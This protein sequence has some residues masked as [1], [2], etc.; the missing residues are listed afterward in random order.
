M[1]DWRAKTR[2]FYGWWLVGALFCILFITGGGGFYVFPVFIQ[3]LIGEFGWTVTQISSA[4]ALWAIVYGFSGPVV[5]ALIARAG[6]RRT[7]VV[8]AVLSSIA[9]LGFARM[10][11]LWLL[12]AA[13]VVLGFS[14]AGTTLVPAQTVITNWFTRYRGRAMSWMMLGIGAGGLLMPPLMEW[15]IRQIGWR[16]TWLVASALTLLVVVPL[17]ALFV[18]TKPADLGLLPDG[19]V[20]RGGGSA[21]RSG[22]PVKLA[23]SS[24]SF[25]LIFSV[26]VFQLV[27]LS[28]MNFHFVPFAIRQAGFSS[29]QAAFFLGMTVGF[30]MA[31]RLAFG[32]LADRSHPGVLMAIAGALLGCGPL[33]LVVL[34]MRLGLAETIVL[35]PYAVLFGCGIAGNAIML[36]VLVG[37]CFGELFFSRLQGLVMSGFAVGIVVG[38]PGAGKIFDATGSY[39]IAFLLCSA[40][41]ALSCVLAL[42]V[43]PARYH[44]GFV[45]E[46]ADS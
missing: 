2:R 35:W 36:P 25:W 14:V 17:V 26:Y 5:G 12:Y 34:V 29:Q 3:S 13:M 11:A 4:A 41:C 38:I 18:R 7:M 31:G 9:Q 30:S 27:A 10:Q 6:V 39:E 22:L 1:S 8:A 33:I 21:R 42:A 20:P 37:R 32:W 46:A 24:R 43:Q 40:A 44:G 45:T 15:L 19:E 16:G 28:A 23:L